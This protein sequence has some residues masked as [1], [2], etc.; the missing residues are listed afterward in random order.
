M[1]IIGRIYKITSTQTNKVYFGSTT[2]DIDKRFEEHVKTYRLHAKGNPHYCSSFEVMQYD[3][4]KI[5]LISKA[6][7]ESRTELVRQEG[8]TIGADSNSCNL[9]IA[10]RT[11]KEYRNEIW[12]PKN[13]EHLRKY[14][15]DLYKKQ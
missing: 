1:T 11:N 14:K 9:K 10:G 6:C 7:Y 12:L 3:D 4:C 15:S 8:I 5:E 2:R 13:K